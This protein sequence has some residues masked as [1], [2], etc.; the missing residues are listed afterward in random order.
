[1]RVE[2]SETGSAEPV[3]PIPDYRFSMLNFQSAVGERTGAQNRGIGARTPIENWKLRIC[4]RKSGRVARNDRALTSNGPALNPASVDSATRWQSSEQ[5]PDSFRLKFRSAIPRD[6]SHAI[7][8]EFSF[9]CV[10]SFP[11]CP[12]GHRRRGR[13]G[14]GARLPVVVGPG[15]HRH[16]GNPTDCQRI[17]RAR[18]PGD[19]RDEE[20][21]GVAWAQS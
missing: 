17:G 9:R 10:L 7:D 5:T 6:S 11:F 2:S 19:L 8:H 14:M 3:G 15:R 16:A 12:K 21:G 1:M 13:C 18:S 20:P 4:N